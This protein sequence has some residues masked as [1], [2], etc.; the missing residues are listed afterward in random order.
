MSN[1]D[2]QPQ[3]IH[4]SGDDWRAAR[5]KRVVIYGMSGLGKTHVSNILRKSGAW[6]HYSVDYRIGTRYM[7]E[8]IV[9]NF[10]KKAM[11][12][13]F[14]AE[15]LRSDSIDI[16]SNI[17]FDNLEPLSTYIGKPGDPARGGI[18]FDEF[19]TRQEQH[20]RAEIDAMHD[21]EYFAGR[22]KD[23]YDYDCFVCDTSGSLIE[24][25]DPNDTDDPVIGKLFRVMLPV[26]IKGNDTHIQMLIE[27]F[28]RDP[29][30]MYYQPEFARA[31]WSEF[32]AREKCSPEIADPDRFVRWGYER[33]L[34][35]RIPKY[36]ALA[37]NWGVIISADDVSRIRQSDDF[38][39]II[40]DAIDQRV[41][42][43]RPG[44]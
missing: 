5:R 41:Q 24:V 43:A 35:Y 37:K 14:L 36:K 11:K 33:L 15:L 3:L 38:V 22:A 28:C 9:D 39:D 29:K 13:P 4:A 1:Q 42:P 12:V 10:K 20:L 27:R 18:P 17:R 44:S 34:E 25:V 26:W 40:A 8:F 31:L 6:F 19:M 16:A 23:I 30:P 32:L 7:G 21:T 2:R